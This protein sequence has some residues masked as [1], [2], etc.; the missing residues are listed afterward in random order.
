MKLTIRA[1]RG[2]LLGVVQDGEAMLQHFVGAANLELP[3]KAEVLPGSSAAVVHLVLEAVQLGLL[4][5]RNHLL[6]SPNSHTDP[7]SEQID[8]IHDRV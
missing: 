3:N 6:P 4:C 8:S 2:S 5:F 1:E 7:T